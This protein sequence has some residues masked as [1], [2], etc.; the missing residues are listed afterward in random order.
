[1]LLSRCAACNG[2]NLIFSKKYRK[3][4]NNTDLLKMVVI[5]SFVE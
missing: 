3:K 4:K 2:K 5:I 1:M